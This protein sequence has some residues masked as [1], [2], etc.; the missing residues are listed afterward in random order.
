MKR[1]SAPD[2]C[3]PV[4]RRRFIQGLGA[5]IAV[6]AAGG[7]G[8]SIWG[9]NPATAIATPPPPHSYGD[10]PPG[11]TLV[12]V[13]MGGGNDGLNTVVPHA[14]SAYYDLRRNLAVEEPIDL[15]GQVGLHPGL[16]YV[17][18]RY[19]DDE[20]AIVEGVGYPDPDLSHFASMSTWW[21]GEPGAIAASG[22]LGRLLDGTTADLDP[23][24]AITIGPGPTPALLAEQSFV[25]SIQDAT[26]LAPDLPPWI[27]EPEE[28]LASWAGFAQAPVDSPALFGQV[29]RAIAATAAARTRLASA[30]AGPDDDRGSGRNDAAGRGGQL[31]RSM[32]LAARLIASDVAP[33]IV[34]VH[35]FGDFDTHQGQQGRHNALMTELDGAVASFFATLEDARLADAALVMTTSEFGRRAASNGSGTD[36]GTAAAHLLIGPAVRGGRHGE[37]P[38]LRRLDARGNLVHTVDY[39]S[40]YATVLDQWFGI[41]HAEVLGAGYP[42][43][44]LIGGDGAGS[45]GA[46]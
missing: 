4:S 40:L 24:A 46:V 5:T 44:D 30:L 19:R 18:A 45:L 21:T 23:L 43:L 26:G 37:A 31:T 42:V 8:I 35:G 1:P 3:L 32:D 36:H 17:A 25:V 7:H 20:V 12:V 15:D 29:Q 34:Y 14:T 6:V 10:L 39:R 11:R 16:D 27:D 38:D 2:P 33:S 13:E 22:W 41:P 9:R 28:L